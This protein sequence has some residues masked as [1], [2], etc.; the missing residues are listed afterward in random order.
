MYVFRYSTLVGIISR[1]FSGKRKATEEVKQA[2]SSD[3]QQ[4]EDE[5]L[6]VSPVPS[7]SKR[8]FMKPTD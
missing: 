1:K 8:K 6:S 3:D 5:E 4:S 2:D 7:K